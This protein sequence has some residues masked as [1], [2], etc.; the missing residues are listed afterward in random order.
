[1]FKVH[2]MFYKFVLFFRV[3]KLLSDNF[4]SLAKFLKIEILVIKFS[5]KK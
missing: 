4:K 1:M 3:L 5:M 2:L